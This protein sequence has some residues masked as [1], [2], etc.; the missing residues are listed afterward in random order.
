M[1][2]VNTPKK[3]T[4]TQHSFLTDKT[5]L[6]IVWILSIP[7]KYLCLKGPVP[8]LAL[9]GGGGTF[10]KVASSEKPSGHWGVPLKGLCS[11]SQPYHAVLPHHWPKPMESLFIVYNLQS[12][13][14]QITSS[15]VNVSPQMFS[16]RDDELTNAFAKPFLGT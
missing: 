11:T 2:V 1:T 7:P 12:C 5:A 14:A 8:R 10:E 9:L 6:E 16:Y 15:L 3:H 13:G 4:E